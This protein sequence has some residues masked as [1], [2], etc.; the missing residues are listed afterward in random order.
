MLYSTTFVSQHLELEATAILCQKLIPTAS[1]FSSRGTTTSSRSKNLET[2]H[3]SSL[4]FTPLDPFIADVFRYV[5][6]RQSLR[7]T[8][9]CTF[10]RTAP[11]PARYTPHVSAVPAFLTA[12]IRALCTHFCSQDDVQQRERRPLSIWLRLDVVSRRHP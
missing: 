9:L 10:S 7:K 11:M 3:T 4:M 5:P 8:S 2:Q 1:R 12:T 6:A